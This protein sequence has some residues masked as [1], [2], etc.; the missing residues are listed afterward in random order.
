MAHFLKNM[1]NTTQI[2]HL[3][4]TVLGLGS[5]WVSVNCVTEI[6]LRKLLNVPDE[7]TIPPDLYEE[8][9]EIVSSMGKVDTA[10]NNRNVHEGQY[11]I[12]EWNYLTDVNNW[13]MSDSAQ[14]RNSLFW[15]D[16]VGL[17][18]GFIEDFSTIVAKWRAYMR[19]AFAHTDWRWALGAQVS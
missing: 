16:R 3:A 19:Y 11:R 2:L 7:L 10:N 8:A 14:R 13:F 1:G 6:A 15:T 5:Q 9:F 12:V 17:E 18:F 4:A